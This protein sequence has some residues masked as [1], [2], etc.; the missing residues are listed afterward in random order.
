MGMLREPAVVESLEAR[1]AAR[2]RMRVVAGPFA[3]E[4]S[5]LL[6][7]RSGGT[8]VVHSATGALEDRWAGLLA[9]GD[10]LARATEAHLRGL[11]SASEASTR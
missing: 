10:P 3:A 6:E 9:G 8:I 1:P 4:W 11:K 2:F 5:W 7:P